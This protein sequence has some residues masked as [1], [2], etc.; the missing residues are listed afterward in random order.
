MAEV[1]HLSPDV[2]PDDEGLPHVP[3]TKEQTQVAVSHADT[4]IAGKHN[5]VGA[6]LGTGQLSEHHAHHEGL[7]YNARDALNAHN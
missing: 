2:R 3:D 4:Y 1:T 6:L 7:Q 5:S